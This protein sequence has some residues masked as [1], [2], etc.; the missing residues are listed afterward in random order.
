MRT[1]TA[2]RRRLGSESGFTMILALGILT[3]ATLIIAGVW[4]AV[5]GDVALSQ[6]DLNG[7]RAYYAADA[8]LNTY[9]YQLNE[10]PDYWETCANDVQGSATSQT[11]LPGATHGEA[12]SFQPVY[13]NGNTACTSDAINSLID[14]NSG[15]LRIEFTGYSGVPKTKQGYVGT[16]PGYAGDPQVSRTI[17]ASFRARSP[18]QFLWYTVFEALDSSIS[19]HSDCGV[20]YRVSGGRDTG[21]NID[22]ATGDVI[23][24]PMYTEDQ[25]LIE[26]GASPTFGRNAADALE[27]TAPGTDKTAICAGGNCQSAVFNG[28][29]QWG[30]AAISPPPNNQFLA[31]DAA[32]HGQV[33]SGTTTIQFNGSS[34][35]VTNCPSTCTTSTVNLSTYPIIYVSNASGCTPPAYSP[36]T[37]TSYPSSGC[38]GDVYVSGNY[39]VPVT[40]AAAN[41]IIIDGNLTTPTNSASAPT[42]PATLGL[43]ANEFVRVMHGCTTGKGGGNVSGQS[44]S[45]LIIDAAILAIQ[46][47]FMVDNY[48]CGAQLGHLTVNGAI[49]QYF[50]GAVGTSAGTGYLKSYT[51]DNRLGY[52]VPPYLFNPSDAGWYLSR[53]SLCGSSGATAC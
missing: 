30:V 34:A 18:F 39:T 5:R 14:T 23:N 42:G 45:N 43:I 36:T 17:V 27:T 52:L 19:G 40:I 10:N 49:A 33:Y 22:W 20:P 16:P 1:L 7:K 29:V 44:F 38:S 51:Y 35:S 31:T 15:V 28:T 41:N 50:R 53:E 21:C 37:V 32:S 9:L 24:G 48:G 8:A 26:T 13:A 47:S 12:Y 4:V 2:I 25:F 3:V 46:H 11:P 6:H